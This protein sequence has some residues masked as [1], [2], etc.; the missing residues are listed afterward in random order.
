M[1]DRDRVKYTHVMLVGYN[2]TLA[3]VPGNPAEC[4]HIEVKID[5]AWGEAE[6][7]ERAIAPALATLWHFMEV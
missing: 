5:P 7:N 2:E 6:L 4:F 1:R 3:H